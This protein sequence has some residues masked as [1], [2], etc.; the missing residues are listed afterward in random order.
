M[1]DGKEWRRPWRR[2]RVPGKGPANVEGW[3]AHKHRGVVGMRFRYLFRPEVGRKVIVGVE[4]ASGFSG[5][6]GGTGFTSIP[7]EERKNLG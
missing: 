2:A 1:V 6:R 5:G 7:T 3:S 4:G